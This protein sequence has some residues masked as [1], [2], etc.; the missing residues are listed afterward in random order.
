MYC[1]LENRLFFI[2]CYWCN[3]ED[4]FFLSGAGDKTKKFFMWE[5][6]EG[7]DCVKLACYYLWI[8]PKRQLKSLLWSSQSGNSP[9]WEIRLNKILIKKKSSP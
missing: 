5:R 3:K 6:G 7:G 4:S 2:S 8:A 1:C 9:Y